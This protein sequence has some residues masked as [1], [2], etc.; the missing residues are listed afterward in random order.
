MNF[1]FLYCLVFT[2][3]AS[4]WVGTTSSLLF[5]VLFGVIKFKKNRILTK[6]RMISL[7]MM[8]E[9]VLASRKLQS[10]E[11]LV[12]LFINIL[13]HYFMWMQ[14]SLGQNSSSIWILVRRLFY[15]TIPVCLVLF[16]VLRFLPNSQIFKN[17]RSQ[18][19]NQIGFSSQSMNPGDV[20]RLQSS[21]QKAFS[22]EV[23]GDV[24]KMYWRGSVYWNNLGF[25]WNRLGVSPIE[26]EIP[27]SNLE[28]KSTFTEGYLNTLD[29]SF[30]IW[31][32]PRFGSTLFTLPSTSEVRVDS[33]GRKVPT[34]PAAGGVF[35]VLV[36]AQSLMV[37]Q[38]TQNLDNDGQ[39]LTEKSRSLY[40]N[41]PKNIK[42]SPRIRA[43]AS[44]LGGDVFSIEQ[45]FLN[46]GFK[47]SL[48]PGPYQSGNI[49]EF[50]FERRSGFCEHYAAIAAN[51]FRLAGVPARVAVGFLGGYRN[52][53]SNLVTVRDSD[54]HAWVEVYESETKSWKI[55]DVT[56]SLISA[57]NASASSW[58]AF[59][60]T[61]NQFLQDAGGILESP[62]FLL[63]LTSW[64]WQYWLDAGK[65]FVFEHSDTIVDV[66]FRSAFSA[67]LL[68]IAYLFYSQRFYAWCVSRVDRYLRRRIKGTPQ[69]QMP[70][71]REWLEVKFGNHKYP[72][73]RLTFF[74]IKRFF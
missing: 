48:S 28:Q 47:Y 68:V 30:K 19:Q 24:E 4:I 39:E 3:G 10:Y 65:D 63:S 53:I 36:D 31:L 64:K 7:V 61:F 12:F 60:K 5:L 22:A 72:R 50:L 44:H 71:W 2:F 66:G 70:I 46:N 38:G 26:L 37:V 25:E 8:V 11:G 41:V 57:D 21:P 20:V 40:L 55:V 74:V 49:E 14:W 42:N 45:F 29:D 17:S 69:I 52:P 13:F 73:L 51:L 54:A 43:L 23:G 33:Y 18:V 34:I 15:T 32:E 62:F 35:E 58:F 67:S 9:I 16:A 1:Y 59:R 27:K 56:A 6:N